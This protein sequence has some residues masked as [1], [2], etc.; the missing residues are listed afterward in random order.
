MLKNFI[1]I[2]L[3]LIICISSIKLNGQSIFIRPGKI[4]NDTQGNPINA[5]GGGVLYHQGTY[6]WFG[7][8]KKGRTWRVPYINTWECYRTDAGGV[9]CYSSKNLRDWKYEGVALAPNLSDSTND[10]HISKVIERPKVIYNEKTKKFVMWMHIDSEDY[11][12]ARAG[13]AVSDNPTGPY[14]Y[15]YSLRPD[16]QMSRDMTLFKDDDGRAYHIYS[17]ENNSTLH[18]GLLTDDYLKPS[19]FYVRIM[20]NNFREAPAMF[21]RKG[22]YYLITSACTGWEPNAAV[23][24]VAD[25]IK[26]QWKTIG[27]P[28]IG[29]KA[30]TTFLSQSTYVIPVEGKTDAYIFMADSWNKTNLEDSRYVW[31]PIKINDNKLSICWIDKWDLSF[32]K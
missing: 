9:S 25:S 12:H 17:S 32:F 5:H 16:D 15:L 28:C 20:E 26:G 23:Y 18:I 7:E 29:Q 24:S 11:S 2:L 19:G 21:K 30:E 22:K 31:L 3:V 10:L 8:K 6:Y 4:W 14:K 1:I 27:N 13:I